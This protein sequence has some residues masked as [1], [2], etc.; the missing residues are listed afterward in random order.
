M[1]PLVGVAALAAIAASVLGRIFAPRLTESVLHRFFRLPFRRGLFTNFDR[2]RLLRRAISEKK[3]RASPIRVVFPA[4]DADSGPVVYF[5][6]ASSEGL[7]P[8]PAADREFPS[9]VANP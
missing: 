6:T 2:T 1:H 9:H 5:S 4:T 7:L 8:A 3:L